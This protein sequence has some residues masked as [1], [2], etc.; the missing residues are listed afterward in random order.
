VQEGTREADL[1]AAERRVREALRNTLSDEHGRWILQKRDSAHNEYALSA[2]LEARRQSIKV[3]RTFVEDQTRWLIDY[4]TSD[5]EGTITESYLREQINKY[6]D[7]LQRYANILRA[8][9][10]MAV[11]GGLYFP[12]LQRW[13][14]VDLTP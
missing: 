2:A 5:Q 11:K 13:C 9:D 6:R 10:G 3:D 4:K 7:D 1:V 12:L 8:F 14:E